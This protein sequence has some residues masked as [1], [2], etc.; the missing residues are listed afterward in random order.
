MVEHSGIV[1]LLIG[2]EG[3]MLLGCFIGKLGLK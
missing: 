3:L 2:I 1:I